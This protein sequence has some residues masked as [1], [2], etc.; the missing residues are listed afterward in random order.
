MEL[1]LR[2][3]YFDLIKTGEKTI[4]LRLFDEK[5]KNIKINDLLILKN[6]ENKNLLNIKVINLYRSNS[7]ENLV[8]LFDIQKTGFNSIEELN[9]C[10]LEFF[11][12]EKQEKYG[13]LGIEMRLHIL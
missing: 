11:T 5:R 6:S 12:K 8:K 3:K 13:V 9:N 2:K 7:F 10:I 4:E 1:N